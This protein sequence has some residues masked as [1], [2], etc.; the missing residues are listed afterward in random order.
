[1]NPSK[2]ML[3]V[4]LATIFASTSLVAF[5]SPFAAGATTYYVSPNGSDGNSGLSTSSPWQT[6]GKV[7][8]SRFNPGD[9]ILFQRGG[10]WHESLSAPSSGSQNNPIPFADYGSGAKPKFWGSVV[11]DNTRFQAVGP[12]IYSYPLQNTAYSV[13]VDHGFFNYAHGQSASSVTHAWS[14]SGGQIRI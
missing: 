12:G 10:Q 8:A 3:S 11:L 9:A 1:M 4:A 5:R 6:V 13:L 2:L 14:Y 7:N